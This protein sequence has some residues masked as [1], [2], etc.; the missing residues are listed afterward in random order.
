MNNISAYTQLLCTI[1]LLCTTNVEPLYTATTPS[2]KC[3]IYN[4]LVQLLCANTTCMHA[5][6]AILYHRP[7]SC[8]EKEM[9]VSSS[10]NCV[11]ISPHPS[12]TGRQKPFSSNKVQA[13]TFSCQIQIGVWLQ[14][15]KWLHWSNVETCLCSW[16]ETAWGVFYASLAICITNLIRCWNVSLLM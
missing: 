1:Q 9:K 5:Y 11:S 15:Y 4:Y 2:Y 3:P 7:T 16:H 14:N 10:K 6:A 13:N 12:H 8:R